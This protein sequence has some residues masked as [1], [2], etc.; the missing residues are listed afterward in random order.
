MNRKR[1]YEI[2]SI[3]KQIPVYSF[4]FDV[5]FYDGQNMMNEPFEKRYSL[6]KD[7]VKDNLL[8]KATET[9]LYEN[10][11]DLEKY[12]LK[13]VD[14][15]LEGIIVKKEHN[16]Y[17]PGTRNF[18]WVK[19]KRAM[20]SHLSDTIDVVVMGYYVGKGK[21]TQ[22]GIG[23]L[24]MGVYDE[25]NNEYATIAKVGTGI[26]DVQWREINLS[27]ENLKVLE[28]PPFY[29]VDKLL[30]PDFW[31]EPK[32]VSQIR[33]DEITRS[34]VHTCGKDNRGI[35]YALRFPRMEIFKRDKLPEDCTTVKEVIELYGI[36]LSPI[37]K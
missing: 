8:I 32:I 4:S 20:K 17:E 33:A 26:T 23:A 37:E 2:G 21:R 31:V 19:L 30:I 13:N 36:Q 34:P 9:I 25:V 28:K 22:L 16:I 15:G 1:K 6:L 14:S 29:K 10:S 7:L 3:S 27:L 5:L 18:N 24:L 11:E 12:F 35:G